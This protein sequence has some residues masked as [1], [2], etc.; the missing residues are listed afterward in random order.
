LR[1]TSGPEASTSHKLC[2][3][4][5]AEKVRSNSSRLI[6]RWALQLTLSALLF[7]T[8]LPASGEVSQVPQ[9][10]LELRG[11]DRLTGTIVQETEE[12]VT[13]RTAFGAEVEIPYEEILSLSRKDP[14]EEDGLRSRQ[15]DES[16]EEQLEVEGELE[17]GAAIVASA[18]NRRDYLSRLDLTFRR[19][20]DH[21]RLQGLI[22][23]QR[24]ADRKLRDRQG[25]AISF[26]K[27]LAEPWFTNISARYLR[28]PT[29]G[30]RRRTSGSLQF[31]RTVFD[32]DLH[33]LTLRAGPGYAEEHRTDGDDWGTP[34]VGWGVDYELNFTGFWERFSFRH[35]QEGSIDPRGRPL[36]LLLESETGLRYRMTENLYL[37]LI[38]SIE[39]DSLSPDAARLFDRRLQLRM[40]FGW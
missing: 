37:A 21:L 28:D 17:L 12:A 34:L 2:E 35:E 26:Q 6:V 10:R 7:L 1:R 18:T 38:G 4:S 29:T 36:R 13:L 39:V 33:S 30:L 22:D 14:A 27:E 11:G 23:I 3:L 15:P 20:R 16:D 19:G 40:G 5:V 25:A 32:D 24:A 31:G 8:A 9:V